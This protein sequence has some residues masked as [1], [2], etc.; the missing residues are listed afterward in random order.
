M[1]F[2]PLQLFTDAHR[3]SRRNKAKGVI[4]VFFGQHRLIILKADVHADSTTKNV[5]EIGD[6]A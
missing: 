2:H 5:T 4:I 1:F 6:S 3:K